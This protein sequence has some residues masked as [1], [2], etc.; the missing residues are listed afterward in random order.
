[1]GFFNRVISDISVVL[2]EITVTISDSIE[3]VSPVE[4]EIVRVFSLSTT[5]ITEKTRSNK[6]DFQ[7]ND[8]LTCFKRLTT[9]VLSNY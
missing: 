8:T 2:R 4:S 9:F 1:M 6:P 7:G 5:E 3:T